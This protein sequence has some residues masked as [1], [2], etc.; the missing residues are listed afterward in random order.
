MAN[1]GCSAINDAD[2]SAVGIGRSLMA[3]RREAVVGYEVAHELMTANNSEVD[4]VVGTSEL[5][6]WNRSGYFASVFPYQQLKSD[7]GEGRLTKYKYVANHLRV[8]R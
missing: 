2:D 4:S 7:D 5:V 6:G 1:P 3:L 8:Q